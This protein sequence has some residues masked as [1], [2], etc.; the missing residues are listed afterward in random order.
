MVLVIDICSTADS[1]AL[2]PHLLQFTDEHRAEASSLQEEL[3]AVAAELAEAVEEI[4][5]KAPE[6]EDGAAGDAPA[7]AS[8]SASASGDSWAA[9]M[10]AHERRRNVNPVDNVARPE[11][12][13]QEWKLKLPA[14]DR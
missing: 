5:K 9:R 3:Q 11:L 2:L 1:A 4:W 12:A 8:A 14:I 6:G 10:E 13:K 7:S